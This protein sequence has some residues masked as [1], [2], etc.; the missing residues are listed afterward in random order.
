M[1]DNGLDHAQFM[2]YNLTNALPALKAG[3]AFEATDP[4]MWSLSREKCK[5]YRWSRKPK[6]TGKVVAVCIDVDV[7]REF[8]RLAEAEGHTVERV[9]KQKV[10]VTP[11]SSSPFHRGLTRGCSTP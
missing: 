5:K 2:M 10:L 9:N 7:L 1:P 4:L 3:D 8:V 11:S 6:P